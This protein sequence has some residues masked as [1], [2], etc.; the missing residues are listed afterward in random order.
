MVYKRNLITIDWT[1]AEHGD[2]YAVRRKSLTPNGVDFTPKLGLSLYRLEPG[3]RAFPAHYH[4]ANDEAILVL[5]GCG[6]LR[7]GDREV[8]LRQG[9]YVHLP[10]GAT[11]AHQVINDSERPLD[12]LCMSSMIDPEILVYPDSEK[13]GVVAGAAPGGDALARLM[14]SYLRNAPVDYWDGEA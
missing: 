3:K 8:P 7:I 4:M 11:A 2:R 6:T 5:D 13:I 9:D 14:N 1:T 10:A 12:Y